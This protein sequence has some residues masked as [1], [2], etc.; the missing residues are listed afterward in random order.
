MVGAM[1]FLANLIAP[2]N[3]GGWHAEFAFFS[4]VVWS[5]ITLLWTP[6]TR[7]LYDLIIDLLGIWCCF[8]L[9]AYGGRTLKQREQYGWFY[10]AG[11]CVS[12]VLVFQNWIV[13]FDF[14]G[15]DRYSSSEY[16]NPNY[17][18]YSI[19]GGFAIACFFLFK[20]RV[21]I[22]GRLVLL[23]S[24]LVGF[25]FAV[26]L[27]GSRGALISC[28]VA[29]IVA[30]NLRTGTRMIWKAALNIAV[31]AIIALS[32]LFVPGD[33]LARFVVSEN[34]DVGAGYASGR[35]DIWRAAWEN[36]GSLWAGEGYDSFGYVSG[37][38]VNA[39]NFIV[40]LTFEM[41]ILGLF[42]YLAALF[43]VV[44]DSRGNPRVVSAS[45]QLAF[46]ILTSWLPIALTGAWALSPVAWVIFSWVRAMSRPYSSPVLRESP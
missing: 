3:G 11:C 46:V 9:L 14:Q 21:L 32:I 33:F 27:T 13:G 41:G 2:R 7:A 29:M 1:N 37:T 31:V 39:H 44:K 18:A 25:A 10:V 38:G 43:Y 17:V 8:T 24:V 40:T 35:L 23:L 4:F 42:T 16:I 20:E 12:S 28:L 26:L 30:I 5:L 36:R 15:S 19:A 6:S 45:Q 22:V 34:Y